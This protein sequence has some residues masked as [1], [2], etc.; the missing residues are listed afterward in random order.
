MALALRLETSGVTDDEVPVVM[1]LAADHQNH[2]RLVASELRRTTPASIAAHAATAAVRAGVLTHD[3]ALITAVLD[4]LS[5]VSTD[6][7]VT[8]ACTLRSAR[9]PALAD[10]AVTELGRRWDEVPPSGKQVRVQEWLFPSTGADE[11]V[12]EPVA[13]ALLLL[14][15]VPGVHP[16][17][18]GKPPSCLGT[19]ASM[20]LVM[21]A[22]ADVPAIS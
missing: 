9:R 4:H 18:G 3:D 11:A 22:I 21:H 19:V 12:R 8:I 7:L 14:R 5:L 13:A 17:S 10:R 16:D 2:P 15:A 20:A 6:D 1:A